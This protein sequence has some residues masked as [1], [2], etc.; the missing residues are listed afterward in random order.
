MKLVFSFRKRV[1]K[2]SCIE[3]LGDLECDLPCSWLSEQWKTCK[4]NMGK[5]FINEHQM[6]F[7]MLM[8]TR[9]E[10]SKQIFKRFGGDVKGFDFC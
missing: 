8:N 7:K 4:P 5:Y 1:R 9:F 2:G 6:V 10:W 3:P